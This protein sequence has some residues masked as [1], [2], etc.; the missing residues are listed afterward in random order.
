MQPVKPCDT[1]HA[2]SAGKDVL[3]GADGKTVLK[4]YFINII[5]RSDPSKVVWAE[6]G[7]AKEDFLK[8]L[9]ETDGAEGVGFVTA[10]PHITKVFRYGPEAETVVNVRAWSTKD[11]A[12]LDLSRS[13]GYVEFACLAEALIAAD[14]Y[15]LWAEAESVAAYL[16]KW[17]DWADGP[18]VRHDKLGV[19]WS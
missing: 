15:R 14:E 5:G 10:F 12:P 18:I 6:C 19:Y 1:Y 11:M 4:V 17:S 16:E 2:V 3:R 9:A 8:A 7:L 13:D